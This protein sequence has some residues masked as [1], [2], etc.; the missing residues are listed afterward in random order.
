M[1][2]VDAP[3][4]V[5]MF[6]DFACKYCRSGSI[7]AKQLLMAYPEQVQVIYKHFPNSRSQG[8]TNA[9]KAARAAAM[10]NRFWDMHDVLFQ[11]ARTHTKPELRDIADILAL[12]IQKFIDDFSSPRQE[13]LIQQDISLARSLGVKGTPAFL[14]NGQVVHNVNS[15]Q[16]LTE[17][18]DRELRMPAGLRLRRGNR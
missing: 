13:Q 17:M 6:S 1:G 12:D 7:K 10:Q 14:I 2:K 5:Y 18:V 11:F 15:A 16:Q 3:I 8:S 9:A 4:K